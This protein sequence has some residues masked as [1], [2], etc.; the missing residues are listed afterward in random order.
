M[1]QAAG[2]EHERRDVCVDWR[3]SKVPPGFRLTATRTQLLE[4]STSPV[5]HLVYSDGLASVSV[6]IENRPSQPDQFKGLAKVGSAFTFSTTTQGHQVTAVGE[7]PPQTVQV[8]AHSTQ[9]ESP[10][11]APAFGPKPSFQL[12]AILERHH[13][14]GAAFYSSLA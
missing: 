10:P 6:F 3:A 9:P 5:T 1:G 4:G 14:H 8:I 7:V 12:R 2:G 11:P 13:D